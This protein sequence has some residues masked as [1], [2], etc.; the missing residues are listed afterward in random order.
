MSRNPRGTQVAHSDTLTGTL[1]TDTNDID[2]GGMDKSITL[3]ADMTIEQ[4]RD[5]LNASVSH[6]VNDPGLRKFAADSAFMEEKVLVRVNPS[7][8]PGAMRIVESW[9]NGVPQRFVRGEWVVAKRM[10]V[11]VLARAKPFSVTT[12][13][14]V[15]GNG[16]R[17]NRIDTHA[18]QLYP[19]EMQDRNPVGQRWLQ[20]ILQ[21]A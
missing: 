4:L 17:T 12:P 2:V 18:G 6:D 19:F 16:D 8:D 5:S 9:C 14:H 3:E 11:E 1:K 13:E 10:F 7:A 20:Q 21:E 15:D